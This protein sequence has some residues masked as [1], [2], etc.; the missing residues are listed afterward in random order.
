MPQASPQGNMG[1]PSGLMYDVMPHA[2]PQ[3]NMGAPSGRM[4][5]EVRQGGTPS[6]RYRKVRKAIMD[7]ISI[8][9]LCSECFECFHGLLQLSAESGGELEE[10]AEAF[11][12]DGCADVEDLFEAL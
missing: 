5:V 2:S 4:V 12:Q 8:A 7:I 11:V 10:A 6:S 3:G 9:R 1:A